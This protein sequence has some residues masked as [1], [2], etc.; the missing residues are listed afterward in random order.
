MIEP[1]PQKYVTKDLVERILDGQP[2]SKDFQHILQDI[3]YLVAMLP[4]IKNG[5][6]PRKDLTLS[7]DK[8]AVAV[9]AIPMAKEQH[10]PKI[11]QNLMNHRNISS[12]TPIQMRNGGNHEKYWYSGHS[13]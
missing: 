10:I 2:L 5:I 4:S 11:Q 1:K 12:I 9:H 6:I 13:L 3:F 8:A 7:G